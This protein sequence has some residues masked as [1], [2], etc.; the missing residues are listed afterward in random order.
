MWEYQ[1]IQ[2]KRRPPINLLKWISN[3]PYKHK[4]LRIDYKH[5]KDKN[6]LSSQIRKELMTKLS[7][8]LQEQDQLSRTLPTNQLPIKFH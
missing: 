7:S 4:D 3:N 5:L 1:I 8:P 2:L 6:W